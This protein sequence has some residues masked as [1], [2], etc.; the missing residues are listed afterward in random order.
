MVAQVVGPSGTRE[1]GY[2]HFQKFRIYVVFRWQQDSRYG[3]NC[4]RASAPNRRIPRRNLPLIMMT[5]LTSVGAR[6][7][8]VYRCV[9]LFSFFIGIA[10]KSLNQE[11][12]GATAAYTAVLVVFVGTS[13]TAT[14][15]S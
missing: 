3:L 2:L 11:V 9:L 8:I 13:S 10:T 14:S 15:Q 5:F 12:L 7:A 6:L 1:D 4:R